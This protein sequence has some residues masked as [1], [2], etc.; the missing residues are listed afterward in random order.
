MQSWSQKSAVWKNLFELKL[1]CL[2]GCITGLLVF[3]CCSEFSGQGESD[4]LGRR[5]LLQSDGA[6]SSFL[7]PFVIWVAIVITM[8]CCCKLRRVNFQQQPH[9]PLQN[10]GDSGGMIVV[11][12]PDHRDAVEIVTETYRAQGQHLCQQLDTYQFH[13]K[14]AHPDH[15]SCPVCLE[16]YEEKEDVMIFPCFHQFHKDCINPWLEDKGYDSVCPVCKQN[17]RDLLRASQ[18]PEFD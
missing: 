7:F 6:S 16:K 12:V 8:W 13:E 4:S 2:W 17:V 15:S 9:V 1:L 5:G 10:G 18:Q 11:R 3:A 14:S